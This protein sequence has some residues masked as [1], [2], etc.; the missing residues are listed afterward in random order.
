MTS[1]RDGRAR[2]TR[3][4]ANVVRNASSPVTIGRWTHSPHGK[5]VLQRLFTWVFHGMRKQY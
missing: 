5:I 2:S 1:A 4:A 3:D